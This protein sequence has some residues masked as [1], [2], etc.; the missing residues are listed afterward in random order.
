LKPGVPGELDHE[1][2]AF[3]VAAILRRDRDLLDPILKTFE[4]FFVPF[5]DFLADRI[6]IVRRPQAL[7]RGESGSAGQS[8][9]FDKSSAIDGGHDEDF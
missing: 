4:R 8:G 3:R 7:V 2:R 6:E 9:A 5:G 1:F